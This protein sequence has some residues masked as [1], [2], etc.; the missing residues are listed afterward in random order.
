MSALQARAAGDR[1]RTIRRWPACVSFV[2][3]G[4]I[5]PTPNT[6]RL[7][8]ALKPR[9]QRARDAHGD[10]GAAAGASSRPIPGLTVFMQPVQDIQI[11]TRVSRTQF[12]YTLVDTDAAELAH[13]AP[14]LLAKLR[15][16]AAAARR[17][18]R[19][20]ERRPRAPSSTS[21]ATP[22]CGSA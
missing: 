3:A 21:T 17:R 16:A 11:G 8:I 6:G 22:R 20:A 5:N 12:Q 1:A 18:E 9:R 15:D 13:W 14:R 4:S 19:P 7:T 2:G 10:R